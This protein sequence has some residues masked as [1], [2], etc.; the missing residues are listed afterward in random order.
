MCSRIKNGA[1][2][3]KAKNKVLY[4]LLFFLAFTMVCFVTYEI[5]YSKNINVAHNFELTEEEFVRLPL[6]IDGLHSFVYLYN[7]DIIYQTIEETTTTF[8]RYNIKTDTAK[9]YEPIANYFMNGKSTAF[10]DNKL[11]F[12]VTVLQK[13]GELENRLYSIDFD[14][15][16]LELILTDSSNIHIFPMTAI[17]NDLLSLRASIENDKSAGTTDVVSFDP[18]TRQEQEVISNQIDYQSTSGKVMISI[19]SSNDKLN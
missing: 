19:S 4:T 2:A 7:E 13:S 15:D 12:Y 14:R 18:G 8:H 5:I 1:G 10:I 16:E 11:F 3:M 9:R 17:N 6:E